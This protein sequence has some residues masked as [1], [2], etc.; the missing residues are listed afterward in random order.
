MCGSLA[1]DARRGQ[2][3]HGRPIELWQGRQVEPLYTKL[4]RGRGGVEG[5]VRGAG[6][7]L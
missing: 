2:S 1:G 7:G 4:R 6:E 3:R 5:R